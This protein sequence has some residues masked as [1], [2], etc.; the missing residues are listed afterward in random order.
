MTTT[1][2]IASWILFIIAGA[3]ILGREIAGDHGSAAGGGVLLVVV[4]FLCSLLLTGLTLLGS[5]G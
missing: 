3:V 1:A 2:F 4:S 5:A